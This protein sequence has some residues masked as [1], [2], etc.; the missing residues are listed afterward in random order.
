MARPIRGFSS[1]NAFRWENDPE[2][3]QGIRI[4]NRVRQFVQDD[5][6]ALAILRLAAADVQ[7]AGNARVSAKKYNLP[8]GS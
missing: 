6:K 5:P 2:A 4:L 3:A 1:F 7:E 8:G